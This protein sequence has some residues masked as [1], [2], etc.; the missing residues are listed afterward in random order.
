V[1]SGFELRKPYRALLDF[2]E[3]IDLGD[4]VELTEFWDGPA[5]ALGFCVDG[6]PRAVARVEPVVAPERKRRRRAGADS[7][8]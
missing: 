6:E 1:D 7:S 2:R 4:E 5:L 8:A 3:P